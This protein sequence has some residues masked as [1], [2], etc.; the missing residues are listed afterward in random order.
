MAYKKLKDLFGFLRQLK[1]LSSKDLQEKASNLREAYPQDLEEG[2]EEEVKQFS[3]LLKTDLASHI[4]KGKQQSLELQYYLLIK[5]NSLDSYFPNVEIA[6]RI[7]L[8]MMVTNCTG[9][10]SFSKLNIIKNHL[11]NSMRQTRLNNLSLIS[12][13][14]SILREINVDSIINEFAQSKFRKHDI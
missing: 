13:E 14:N 12:I 3:E 9:E 5:E 4:D 7:Y 8:S 11:R 2:F 1:S 10:R 6:L